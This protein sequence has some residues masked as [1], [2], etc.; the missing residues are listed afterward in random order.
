MDLSKQELEVFNDQEWIAKKVEIVDRIF[1]ELSFIQKQVWHQIQQHPTV[2]KLGLKPGKV[3]KG[4]KYQGYLPYLVLDAPSVFQKE[5]FLTFRLII[6]WGERILFE[7]QARNK[8]CEILKKNIHN[9]DLDVNDYVHI[10]NDPW[11]YD[12]ES[13]QSIS[14]STNIQTIQKDL[15]L[16]RFYSISEMDNLQEIYLKFVLKYLDLLQD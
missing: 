1:E 9:S 7:V 10:S 15:K 8:Y 5:D 12:F 6:I 3:S 16:A 4:E 11:N 2:V 13:Y 14:E